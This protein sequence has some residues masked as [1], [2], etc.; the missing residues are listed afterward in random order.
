MKLEFSRHILEKYCNIRFYEH[1][2]MGTDLSH[3]GGQTDRQT[4]DEAITRFSQ[5]CEAPKMV[6]TSGVL[7]YATVLFFNGNVNV[8]FTEVSYFG[9]T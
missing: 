9:F 4:H 2:S 1:P 3:A 5:F 8:R 7:K 6:S